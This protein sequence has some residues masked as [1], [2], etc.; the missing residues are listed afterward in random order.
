MSTVSVAVMPFRNLSSEP[1]TEYFANGFVE[2][3][4]AELVRFPSLRVLATQST[5]GVGRTGQAIADIAVKWNLDFVLEGSV[6]KAG[7]RVRITAQL[8]SADGFH[9]WA[10]RYDRTLEDVFAV[11]EEIAKAITS[12]LSVALSPA[13]EK[14]LG[15]DRPADVRAYDLYLK[16]R[17][18][19][20]R[21][22]SESMRAAIRWFEQAIALESNYALAHAGISPAPLVSTTSSSSTIFTRSPCRSL[23]SGQTSSNSSAAGSS[24]PMPPRWY[25]VPVRVSVLP[26][27]SGPARHG[28][29][30]RG[31]EGTS[32]FPLTL[33]A[34]S[35]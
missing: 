34:S 12:A 23:I 18:E 25:L 1:D 27:S 22:T 5:F 33:R 9:L 31:R 30:C 17:A 7:N 19:Y 24:C 13:E 11:Q 4:T 20:S 29:V 26:A 28:S 15:Q 35:R 32:L 10:E 14:R 16:G 2:D 6:R 3:L 8:V 21:Y